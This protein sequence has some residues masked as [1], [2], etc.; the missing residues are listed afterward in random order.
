MGTYRVR[1]RMDVLNLFFHH[2]LIHHTMT[3]IYSFFS[4]YMIIMAPIALALAVLTLTR[5]G[6]I[7][8]FINHGK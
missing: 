1:R 3:Q 2:L 4:N 7:R 8:H 6:L 5:G